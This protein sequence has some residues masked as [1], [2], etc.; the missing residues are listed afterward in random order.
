[1][2]Y[3]PNFKVNTIWIKGLFLLFVTEIRTSYHWQG[4]VPEVGDD[5]TVPLLGVTDLPD[6][7]VRNRVGSDGAMERVGVVDLGNQDRFNG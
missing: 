1:M 6:H 3:K 4:V 7:R 5:P 2:S